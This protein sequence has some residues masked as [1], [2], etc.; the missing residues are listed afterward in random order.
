[1]VRA[2]EL[3]SNTRLVVAHLFYFYVARIV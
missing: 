2:N 1:L 3:R